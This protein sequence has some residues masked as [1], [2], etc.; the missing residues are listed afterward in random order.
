MRRRN[1]KSTRIFYDA[2][3][4]SP[5]KFEKIET[6]VLSPTTGAPSLIQAESGIIR[7]LKN[8]EQYT[9]RPE[10]ARK[11]FPIFVP[12]FGMITLQAQ[13]GW[14]PQASEGVRKCKKN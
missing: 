11:R 2:A 8:I 10:K 13:P 9:S 1:F 5:H 14:Q 7:S 3:E 12:S 6:Y 4:K